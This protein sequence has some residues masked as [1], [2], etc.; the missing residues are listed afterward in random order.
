M[1]LSITFSVLATLCDCLR[2]R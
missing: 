2:L 1:Y